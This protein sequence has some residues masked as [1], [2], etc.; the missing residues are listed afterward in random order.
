MLHCLPP[1]PMVNFTSNLN[2]SSTSA[3]PTGVLA[4]LLVFNI[5]LS[6]TASLGNVLILIALQKV[7]SLHPPTKLLFQCLAV[8]DL[9]VG[10]ISQP[11]F[12]ATIY[13][14]SGRKGTNSGVLYFLGEAGYISS[15]IL[16]GVS[17]LTSTAISADRFL[18]LA[19]GL[20]YRHV[21]TLRRVRV[22]TLFSWLTAVFG[23]LVCF[24]NKFLPVILHF[25]V[26]TLL[27]VTSIFC[28]LKIF[29]RLWEHQ[30]QVQDIVNQRQRTNRRG[31]GE[32]G[33]RGRVALNV[34]QYKKTVSS[35]FWV[36]VALLICY[37]P[38]IIMSI[39]LVFNGMLIN[40]L[41]LTAPTLV[42]L[43][44]SLNPILYCW[45]IREVR[46]AV[47]NSIRQLCCFCS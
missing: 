39:L 29:L 1:T 32:E 21:V 2:Q 24:W 31:R 30:A 45:R 6:F 46:Q 28:Y 13:L 5:F 4:F 23:G 8:T 11:L 3:A 18:A 41:W 35:I 44:S 27:L 10:L 16:C 25:V 40:L 42:Y 36:Q 17:A 37:V 33:E 34:T 12:A 15:F 9:C 47:T 20:R 19:L 7:S 14:N 26:G 38:F 43:N 22:V